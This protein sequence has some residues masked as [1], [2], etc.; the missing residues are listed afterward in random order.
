MGRTVSMV[1]TSKANAMRLAVAVVSV[2]AL[3]AVADAET[4]TYGADAGFGQTDNI[5]LTRSNKVSQTIA[6]VD[7]DFDVKHQSRRLDIDAKGNFTDYDYLQSAYGNQLLGRFDGVAH[8]ALI[9]QKLTWVFHDTFGQAALDPFVPNTPGNVENVNNFSTGPDLALRVGTT[10]FIDAGLRY[11]RS[12]FQT[13]PDNSNRELANFAAGLQLSARSSVSLHAAAERV[14]FVD[15]VLN[16][17]FTRSSGYVRYEIQGARTFLSVDL[18]ATKLT[19]DAA[20]A[21]VRLPGEFG[22]L[23][24]AQNAYST[25]GPLARISV[26]RI[27]S[28]TATL[29]LSGS[30]ELTDASSSFSGLQG[31]AIGVVGTA[32]AVLTS[33]SYTADSAS[34]T[35]RYMRNRTT[36]AVSGRWEKDVYVT[37][38][39]FDRTNGGVELNLSRLLSRAFA[40]QVIGRYGKTNYINAGAI[41]QT[42]GSP[43]F[44][45]SLVGAALVWRHGRAMEVRLRAEHGSRTTTG[46]DFGYQETRAFLTVGYRPFAQT[47]NEMPGFKNL[48]AIDSSPAAEP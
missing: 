13:S 41:V 34:V 28:S 42:G 36:I 29:T 21:P 12:Q 1:M 33:S 31:G 30:R 9:P 6:T 27:L 44:D 46:P 40:L 24:I 19:Q 45:D 18:G 32:S 48:P 7:A 20:A 39:Q 23:P 35:W 5:N 14:L 4:L 3:A 17:N 43:K 2:L 25:T 22:P 38:P 37:Q 15:T 26:S 11:A 16:G 8:V 10:G 47:A